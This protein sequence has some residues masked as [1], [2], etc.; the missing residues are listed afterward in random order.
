MGDYS[1]S[2]TE[3]V[4]EFVMQYEGEVNCLRGFLQ[5]TKVTVE[6]ARDEGSAYHE[7]TWLQ[8]RDVSS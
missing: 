2:Q 3:E 6:D 4:L 5:Q 8:L 1:I 7:T